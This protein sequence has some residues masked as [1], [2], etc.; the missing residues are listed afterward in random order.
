MISFRFL[1]KIFWCKRIVCYLPLYRVRCPLRIH[2]RSKEKRKKEGKKMESLSHTRLPR[3]TKHIR[4]MPPLSIVLSHSHAH[5]PLSLTHT[6]TFVQIGK[7]ETEEMDSR[8]TSPRSL[9]LSLCYSLSLSLSHAHSSHT[10]PHFRADR[11]ERNRRNGFARD[12][13]S[14][15]S[16]ASESS[17]F[18]G[19]LQCAAVCC[20][21][22]QPGQRTVCFRRC[23]ALCCNLLQCSAVFCSVLQSG[24][25]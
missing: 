25:A 5:T 17:V 2:S 13:S 9:S 8:A 22:L 24:A 15:S 21:V 12:A 14:S 20:S 18:V 10:H 6:H 19:V 16:L 3:A 1:Q 11:Q 4:T 7:S 23:I